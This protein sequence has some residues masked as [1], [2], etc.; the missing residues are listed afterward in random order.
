MRVPEEM[1]V[2][3]FKNLPEARWSAPAPTTVRRPLAEMAAT[4]LRPLVRMAH[5]ERPEGTRTEPSTRLVRRA[6]TAPPPQAGPAANG[7]VT[8]QRP[9]A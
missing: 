4:A 3:G 5:G 7:P 2:V 9:T 8:A 6:N 1:S